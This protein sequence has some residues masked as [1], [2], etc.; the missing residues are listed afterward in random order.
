MSNTL[1]LSPAAYAGS[2]DAVPLLQV[3]GL[4]VDYLTT[5]GPVRACADVDLTVRRGEIIGIAGESA[6]GK[7]TLL[8]ALTRLQRPPAV[9]AAGSIIYQPPE[10]AP[11]DLAALTE[12][13]LSPLRWQDISIVMQSAMACLNPVTTIGAQFRDVLR[14]HNPGMSK[15]ATTERAAQLLRL[16]GIP[17][18]RIRSYPHQMSGG[19]RQRTLIA[20]ALACEP[21]L[22]VMDEPTTAVDVVT[23]RHILDQ[24]IRLQEQLGFAV[25]FVTHDLSLLIEIS[26]RIA[27]MY[28]GRIVELGSAQQIFESPLHP[29]TRGLRNA[30]PPLTA[31]LRRLTGIPGTPPD[32]RAL[33]A[34]CAFAPRCAHRMDVC[35]LERPKLL[36][37]GDGV[38]ACH[39][40]PAPAAMSSTGEGS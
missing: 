28:G 25:V 5:E 24:I 21:E 7:S 27:I 13:Q 38:A 29:Y 4:A 23:Q 40:H 12:R 22:V 11:V 8:T 31:P 37:A 34:G 36:P 32:L 26:D 1:D 18:D 20:L 9:T 30:Y 15:A 19:M 3:N 39:L 14:R 33:P 10:G 6:S 17:A 16:V 35:D 2:P